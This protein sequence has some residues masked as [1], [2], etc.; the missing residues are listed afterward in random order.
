MNTDTSNKRKSNQ[1]HITKYFDGASNKA[2]IVNRGKK[3]AHI[4][5]CGKKKA[6]MRQVLQRVW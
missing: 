3:K 4:V 1:Q 5:Q 6:H 2:N